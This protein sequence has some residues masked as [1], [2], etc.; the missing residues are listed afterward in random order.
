MAIGTQVD[1]A[2]KGTKINF[3]FANLHILKFLDVCGRKGENDQ[4]CKE[5]NLLSKTGNYAMKIR[6]TK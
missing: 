4:E 3:F 2:K 1:V 6:P 5:Q